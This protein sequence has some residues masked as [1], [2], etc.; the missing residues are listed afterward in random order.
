[1]TEIEVGDYVYWDTGQSVVSRV[2]D[3]TNITVYDYVEATFT[4]KSFTQSVRVKI[5]G[6][7]SAER[8]KCFQGNGVIKFGQGSVGEVYPEWWGAIANDS[9]VAVANSAAIAKAAFCFSPRASKIVFGMGQYYI[10]GHLPIMGGSHYTGAGSGYLYSCASE[11]VMVDTGSTDPYFMITCPGGYPNNY[12]W[13]V[14]YLAFNGNGATIGGNYTIGILGIAGEAGQVSDCQFNLL[15]WGVMSVASTRT[16]TERNRFFGCINGIWTDTDSQV[17]TNE[18][19]CG[20]Q[21]VQ[22]TDFS[23]DTIWTKG[24]NWTISGGVATHTAGSTANLSQALNYYNPG[25]PVIIVYTC[26]CSAGSLLPGFGDK[27]LGFALPFGGTFLVYL[28]PTVGGSVFFTPSNDFAGTV[29]NVKVYWGI[30]IREKNG[31]SIVVNNIVFGDGGAVAALSLESNI[32]SM[33][34]NNRLGPAACGMII[35]GGG[36]YIHSNSIGAAYYYGIYIRSNGFLSIKNNSIGDN[37]QYGFSCPFD[38]FANGVLTDNYFTNNAAGHIEYG[39]LL[40]NTTV[41]LI[42]NN[43]GLDV[44]NILTFTANDTTPSVLLGS[45]FKTANSSPTVITMFDQGCVGKKIT[46][47]I[48]DANTS[49]DFSGTNLK[50]QSGLADPWVAGSGDF[51][52]ATFDGTNWY[53]QVTEI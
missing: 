46:V 1:V 11:L 25:E 10:N 47:I 28:R 30:G 38:Q 13:K 7:F 49:I 2:V 4:G 48:N 36:G 12:Y 34:N 22:N 35:D 32:G 26:T 6:A 40:T 21:L 27:N 43:V 24:A 19:S 41:P 33:L 14:D 50:A 31:G 23:S 51:L 5:L 37:L 44:R 3:A 20:L 15:G 53:C 42:E 17:I 16:I 45:K 52:T 8:F 39:T 29:D 9:A 18:V